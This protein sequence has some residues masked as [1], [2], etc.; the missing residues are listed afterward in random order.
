MQGFRSY[1]EGQELQN[2]QSWTNQGGLKLG[3]HIEVGL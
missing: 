2:N 1:H 3:E